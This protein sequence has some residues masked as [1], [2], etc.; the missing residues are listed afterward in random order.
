MGEQRNGDVGERTGP[1]G[2]P[3][4]AQTASV[5]LLIALPF[6][7]HF[8]LISFPEADAFYHLRH[9]S[10]YVEK[11]PFYQEFPWHTQ[12][13]IGDKGADIWY[14]FHI[15]LIPFTFI[16]DPM[17]S[18]R[19]ASACVLIF[20]LLA[21]YWV[22]RTE[23]WPMPVLWPIFV[24]G[25]SQIEAWR[26]MALRP[27]LL[28][29]GI[30]AVMF[31]QA[32]RGK[33]ILAALLSLAIA[34]VH[35][36]FFWVGPVIACAVFAFR[37]FLER[38]WDLVQ[39]ALCILFAGVGLFARPDAL[40]ALTVLKVQL[41]DLNEA[42]NSNPYMNFGTEVF[43]LIRLGTVGEF[44]PMMAI[45][46]GTVLA[47]FF[48]ARKHQAQISP[49]MKTGFAASS[50]LFVAFGLLSVFKT[51]RATEAWAL[52]GTL[53]MGYAAAMAWSPSR[54]EAEVVFTRPRKV[55]SG[56]LATLV[57]LL[58]AA[59]FV[60]SHHGI[61]AGG[62]NIYTFAGAMSW[63]KRNSRPG[64][65]VYHT[66]WA[67]FAEM[68]FWNPRGRYIT[69]MDPIF[70][71][72]HDRKLY[73][74][75]TFVES[76]EAASTLTASSPGE[77]IVWEDTHDVIKNEFHA[78]YVFATPYFTPSFLEYLLSDKKKFKLVYGDPNA[79]VFA[80]L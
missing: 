77:P 5:L 69:G 79:A 73:R 74:K 18:L 66:H 31:V 52:F 40:D 37:G 30:A 11:G 23:R 47:G 33:S 3:S 42:L 68:F 58:A 4:Y 51:H 61:N 49:Q 7:L 20:L 12:S 65:I 55:L 16:A 19:V 64:D 71:Y 53:S 54:H 60:L 67:F 1:L 38:K 36:A 78:R 56:V 48:I 25:G 59:S 17:L 6:I 41:V 72:S 34:W 80:V 35:P 44:I 2:K 29:L 24:L 21:V 45:W 46:M 75:F 63:L 28:S 22:A 10:I 15:L 62:R 57:S 27:F 9:A 76:D 43:P 13:V 14:G 50:A 8:S 70:L 39:A 26:W 32:V